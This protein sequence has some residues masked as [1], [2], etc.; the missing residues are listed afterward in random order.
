MAAACS[1]YLPAKTFLK[2][3]PSNH[4][5]RTASNT[6]ATSRG[7]TAV[8]MVTWLL[9]EVLQTSEASE[10][11]NEPWLE[12]VRTTYVAAEQQQ[13]SLLLLTRMQG[14]PLMLSDSGGWTSKK[15][16]DLVSIEGLPWMVACDYHWGQGQPTTNASRLWWQFCK[17]FDA[18]PWTA[19]SIHLVPQIVQCWGGRQ[20]PE[21]SHNGTLF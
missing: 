2:K 17:R 19:R 21:T 18:C 1:W 4:R 13:Y 15:K 20:P 8:L 3:V 7:L 14:S 5:G 6:P 10:I 9:L 11:S 12:H 16:S